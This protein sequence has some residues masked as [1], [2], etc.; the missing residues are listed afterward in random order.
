MRHAFI[1]LAHNERDILKKILAYLNHDECDLYLNIDCKAN[2]MP[3]IKSLLSNNSNIKYCGHD[4]LHWGGYSILKTEIKMLNL[5]LNSSNADYFHIISGQDYPIKTYN[6][7]LKFFEE[8]PYQSYFDCRIA[9][10][11][12]IDRRLLYFLPYDYYQVRNPKRF[13]ITNLLRGFQMRHQIKR[14]TSFFPDSIYLG[15]QW[16]SMTKEACTFLLAYTKQHPGFFKRLNHT[17]AA[18]EIYIHTILLNYYD[19]EKICMD[20]NLRFIRWRKENGNRPANLGEEHF[21][22]MVDKK[23]FFARK[24]QSPISTRLIK[25]IDFYL[26]KHYNDYASCFDYD[27]RIAE[28]LV[29]LTNGLNIASTLIVGDNLVYLDALLGMKLLA[30]GIC[31]NQKAY[32]IAQKMNIEQYCQVV[33]WTKPILME[34]EDRYDSLLFVNQLTKK[35]DIFSCLENLS[36][37]TSRYMIFV[38][39]NMPVSLQDKLS[40]KLSTLHLTTN[41]ELSLVLKA[42]FEHYE[43]LQICVLTKSEQYE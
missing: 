30:N 19:K 1:I 4:R 18:E 13:H 12:E 29:K 10:F 24:M 37:L 35:E 7:F 20:N 39:E 25:N 36:E 2:V 31:N 33:D 6:D 22:F 40:K 15:S 41:K 28:G 34:D 16:C 3:E 17:F 32:H 38:E 43:N 26:L 27:K 42:Y 21:K 11:R 14:T 9:T 23:H 5:A 8:N